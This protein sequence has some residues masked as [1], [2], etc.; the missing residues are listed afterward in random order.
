MN[1]YDQVEKE[2]GEFSEFFSKPQ[3][4][5]FR[6]YISGILKT[7]NRKTIVNIN[8]NAGGL[9]D[10]S[11]LNR[12]VTNPKWDTDLLKQKYNDNAIRTVVNKSGEY[13]FLIF[14]DTI[15]AVSSKNKM[16]GVE[17]YFDHAE[18]RYVWGHKVFTSCIT[19]G[20]GFTTPFEFKMYRRRLEARRS[21]VPYRKITNVAKETIEKFA[22]YDC[23]GKQKVALFDIYYASQRIL[24]TCVKLI[25]HFVTKV[26]SN[27]K[28]IVGNKEMHARDVDKWLPFYREVKI[29][30]EIYEYSEPIQVEWE[31]VGKMFLMRSRLKGAEEVQYYITDLNLSGNAILKTYSNRWE[32]EVMHRDLKQNFGFGD[33]MIRNASSVKTH[34]LLSSI[35]YAIMSKIRYQIIEPHMK[36]L[37]DKIFS[38]IKEHFTLGL[39]CKFFRKNVWSEVIINLTGV[40]FMTVK[41]AKL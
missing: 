18:K 27:K 13:V 29:K 25:V 8:D 33:Y 34:I 26:K 21:K 23:R 6:E 32:I 15:K 30:G 5:H 39:L 14:D 12:F 28:F 35:A 2:L 36:M 1:I 24:R 16:E 22:T 3:L 20:F 9:K 7:T 17:K 41:N 40:R 19:N 31:G 4:S 38:K 10:Q 37:N 11:Q